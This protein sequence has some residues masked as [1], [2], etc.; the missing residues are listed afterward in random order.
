MYFWKC[1]RES[2]AQL[3]VGVVVTLALCGV[4]TLVAVKIGAPGVTP[5]G[6]H[7]ATVAQSQLAAAMANLGPMGGLMALIWGLVL[8]SKGLGKEFEDKTAEVLFTRPKRR[9]YWVWAGWPA[10][11][12]NLTIIVFA[13][14]ATTYGV[15]F[16]FTGRFYTWRLLAT[17]PTL[18]LCG[19]VAYGLTYFLTV[20]TRSA[21]QAQSY[22]LGLLIIAFLFRDLANSYLKTHLPP[23]LNL[24]IRTCYWALGPSHSFPFVAAAGWAIVA[25]AFPL[26]SQLIVEH[27][28]V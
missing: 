7:P 11:V 28:Q 12:L 27:T 6:A 24:L 15:S 17:I 13:A 4:N 25:L 23:L 20:A 3:I 16:Y 19:A 1:W 9:R 10:G 14:A 18:T 22:A 8:G 2:R 26:A 21:R 5:V